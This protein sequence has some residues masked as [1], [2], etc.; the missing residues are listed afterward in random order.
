MPHLGQAAKSACE[1]MF[2]S[3]GK[4]LMIEK[5]ME[6]PAIEKDEANFVDRQAIE[7]R[8][9]R[10]FGEVAAKVFDHAEMHAWGHGRFPRMGLPIVSAGCSGIACLV[11]SKNNS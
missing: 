6:L 5:N 11:Q 3:G 2:I 8:G 10:V 4:F 9:F 7:C 1:S